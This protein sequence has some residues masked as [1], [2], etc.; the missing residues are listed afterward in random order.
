M[1][2]SSSVAIICLLTALALLA[3]K[4]AAAS[5]TG[6]T[7]V[8][9]CD[10]GES[11]N[12]AL[13][14]STDVLVVEV[15]GFCRE[16]VEINREAITLKGRAPQ[17]DGV[18]GI[19]TDDFRDAAVALRAGRAVRIE[20]LQLTGEAES[21]LRVDSGTGY[22]ATIDNCWIVGN[23]RFGLAILGHSNL[24][25]INSIFR[26]NGVGSAVVDTASRFQCTRC[27]FVSQS[28]IGVLVQASGLARILDST[29]TSSG[30]SITLDVGVALLSN[31]EVNG[32][33]GVGGKSILQL[34]RAVQR[35]NPAGRN[36]V[37][38]DSLLH[39]STGS[40]IMGPTLVDGFSSFLLDAGNRHNGDLTCTRG[41]D[42]FC[43]G[44]SDLSGVATGCKN[45]L[46]EL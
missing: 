29:I 14:T 38:Q 37:T 32:S 20:N 7:V 2:H 15:L 42:A 27:S 5:A 8:V 10:K 44:P 26:D 9:N 36:E 16:N 12:G 24:E 34:E 6:K 46:G 31:T 4:A 33:I 22:P 3:G 45:C 23:K 11:I 18:R 30:F 19:D 41:S 25:A 28:S 39:V 17:I 21:G 1:R 43:T 40:T 35:S 13:K